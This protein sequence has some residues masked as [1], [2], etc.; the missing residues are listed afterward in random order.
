MMSETMVPVLRFG[1]FV[2]EWE[3]K[4][5]KNITKV[6]DGTH[7]T[8]KYVTKGIPFFSVEHVTANQFTKTK[9]ISKEVFEKENKRVKLEK[10]DVLMTRIGSVGIAKYIDW[11]VDA[12]FYVSLALI[13]KNDAHSNIYLAQYIHSPFFQLELWKKTIHVAFPIKINL[14]EI[15]KCKLRIP[16]LPEQKKIATFLTTID[17]RI[18]QLRQKQSLWEE[19]KKGVMQQ[20][21]SQKIRFKKENGKKFPKWE[22][23]KLGTLTYK[24]G[25]KNKENIK[26]PVY[27]INN[28]EGFLPQGNQFD[29]MDSNDRGYDI[30]LYKIIKENTFAYNPARINV[31]SIGFSGQ[32]NDVIVSSL[33]VCFKTK[34]NLDDYYLLQYLQTYNFNKAVS[35]SAEGGVRS[36]LFYDNFSIIKIPLPSLE[37]QQRIVSFLEKIDKRTQKI[38]SQITEMENYKKGLLQQM[39]V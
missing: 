5:L 1:E 26:Y 32:L 7:Q 28:K 39:F 6:F 16:S 11:S 13:K 24:T 20:L 38:T 15:G 18:Q 19:Y 36:Y 34:E 21:F 30:S 8:P 3:E 29:G 31:G 4:L 33:Y 23:T 17:T 25:K 9:Y 12:S 35:R 22:K 10:G 37:E 27:S 2:E 14:G